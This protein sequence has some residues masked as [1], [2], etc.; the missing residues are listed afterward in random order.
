MRK[1]T[2]LIGLFSL[3]AALFAADPHD[4]FLGTWK[5]NPAKS[6]GPGLPK[7]RMIVIHEQGESVHTT[8]AEKA[9]DGIALSYAFDLPKAGGQGRISGNPAFD[10]ISV[11]ILD[12]NTREITY[13]KA[14]RAIRTSRTVLAKDGKSMTTTVT[15]VDDEGNPITGP[16]IL[17]SEQGVH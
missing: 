1:A 14:G 17:V 5:L 13:M 6:S 15:G 10:G 4:P 9:A 7:E 2:N 8:I 16:I 3:A 12:D 11:T